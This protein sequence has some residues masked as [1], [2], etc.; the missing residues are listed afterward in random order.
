MIDYV[1]LNFR[2]SKFWSSNRLIEILLTASI[3]FTIKVDRQIF[4]FS[5]FCPTDNIT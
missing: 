2:F 1:Y 5:R 4:Y 3:I